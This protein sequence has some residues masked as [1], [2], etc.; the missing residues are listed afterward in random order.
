MPL[1]LQKSVAALH[2]VEDIIVGRVTQA[3][4]AEVAFG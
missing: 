3:C 1:S 2:I 4:Q